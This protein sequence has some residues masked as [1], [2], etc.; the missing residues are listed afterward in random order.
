MTYLAGKLG[1]FAKHAGHF[2]LEGALRGELFSCSCLLYELRH[3]GRQWWVVVT[4]KRES[5]DKWRDV[6]L[7]CRGSSCKSTRQVLR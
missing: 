4:K 2:A 6:A 7:R 3:D 1:R 5:A